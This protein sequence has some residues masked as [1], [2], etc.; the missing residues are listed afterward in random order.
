MPPPHDKRILLGGSRRSLRRYGYPYLTGTGYPLYFLPETRYSYSMDT[1]T[2]MT[3]E[4]FTAEYEALMDEGREKE[5]CLL[6][7][8]EE[9]LYLR[10]WVEVCGE[11]LP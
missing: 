7:Q 6:A 10:Y 2:L 4:Q 11:E 1:D 3:L 9:E 5:A 8:V